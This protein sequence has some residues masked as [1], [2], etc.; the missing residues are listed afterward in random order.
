MR[1]YLFVNEADTW[2]ISKTS[3][4]HTAS[5]KFLHELTVLHTTDIKHS[6]YKNWLRFGIMQHKQTFVEVNKTVFKEIERMQNR[7]LN[8]L[9]LTQ[10]FWK[11]FFSPFSM[12][13][14][15]I[16]STIPNLHYINFLSPW[17][18]QDS[19]SQLH[20]PI[21]LSYLEIFTKLSVQ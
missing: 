8:Y 18:I 11:N 7:I 5:G 4:Y 15:I 19:R 16:C 3:K 12:K 2:F 9:L 20:L 21:Y 10:N 6:W 13:S 17:K 14:H 1:P